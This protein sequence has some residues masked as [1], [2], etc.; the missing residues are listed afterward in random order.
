MKSKTLNVERLFRYLI[1]KIRKSS[2]THDKNET[3]IS[4]CTVRQELELK[5]IKELKVSR[6]G[7]IQM[8]VGHY[9]LVFQK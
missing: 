4:V 6:T 1:I 9:S 8:T 2:L 5:D 3:L 7:T